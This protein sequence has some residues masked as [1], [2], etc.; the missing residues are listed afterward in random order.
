MAVQEGHKVRCVTQQPPTVMPRG[1]H[2][3]FTQAGTQHDVGLCRVCG[4][5]VYVASL[6]VFYS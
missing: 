1:W 5:C 2:G 3:Q 4:A 6:H